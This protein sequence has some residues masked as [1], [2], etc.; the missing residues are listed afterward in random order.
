ME[1][2]RFKARMFVTLQYK[3][4]QLKRNDNETIER[5]I[6][7]IYLKSRGSV[8]ITKA[9]LVYQN[10]KSGRHDGYARGNYY[11]IEGFVE[12]RSTVE[13]TKFSVFHEA[14]VDFF[15]AF[16]ILSS[17]IKLISQQSC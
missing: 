12:K 1:K 11:D 7:D 4:S 13:F 2:I 9:D 16:P 10:R 6:R 15:N 17:S 5:Y 14:R 3:G 8:E